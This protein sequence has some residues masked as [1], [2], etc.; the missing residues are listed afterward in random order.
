M[1]RAAFDIMISCTAKCKSLPG[2]WS[3]DQV[4]GNPSAIQPRCESA[5]HRFKLPMLTKHSC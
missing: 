4:S 2:G 5:R 1:A 3:N